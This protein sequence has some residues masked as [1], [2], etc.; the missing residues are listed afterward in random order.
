MTDQAHDDDADNLTLIDWFAAKYPEEWATVQ[1]ELKDQIDADGYTV[2]KR[3][4][5]RPK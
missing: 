3:T 4:R 5:K 1:K 2:R